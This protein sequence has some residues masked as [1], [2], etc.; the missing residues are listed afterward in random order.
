MIKIAGTMTDAWSVFFK[1]AF[2]P[3]TR[4]LRK[5]IFT[6]FSSPIIIYFLLKYLMTFVHKLPFF[7]TSKTEVNVMDATKSFDQL[8]STLTP[9]T[10]AIWSWISIIIAIYL[11]CCVS[12]LIIRRIFDMGLSIKTSKMIMLVIIAIIIYTL[13]PM[14]SILINHSQTLIHIST[15]SLPYASST[16]TISF[17]MILYALLQTIPSNMFNSKYYTNSGS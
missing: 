16:Y 1:E 7:V 6:I 17:I 5:D 11:L 15:T 10:S 13:Y 14:I 3:K 4:A 2:T 12:S 9:I 8:L